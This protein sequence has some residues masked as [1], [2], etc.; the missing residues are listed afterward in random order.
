[1]FCL[2]VSICLSTFTL[3]FALL[4]VLELVQTDADVAEIVDMLLLNTVSAEAAFLSAVYIYLIFVGLLFVKFSEV[5]CTA[6]RDLLRRA[7]QLVGN[8]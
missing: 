1:M 7:E 3:L 2:H 8:S 5:L 4:F 6:E